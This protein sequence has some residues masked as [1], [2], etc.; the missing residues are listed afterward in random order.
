MKR[1]LMLV[2]LSSAVAAV[3][4]EIRLP[5]LVG[6]NMVLQQQS[7]VQI[8]GWSEPSERIK[9]NASWR[10]E[11]KTVADSEGSWQ[12]TVETSEASFKP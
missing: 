11:A 5:R 9:V 6:D 2:L 12:V 10:A 7:E 3:S 8:W 4:G 1:F